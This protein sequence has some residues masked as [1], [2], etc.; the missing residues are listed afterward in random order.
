MPGTREATFPRDGSRVATHVYKGLNEGHGGRGLASKVTCILPLRPFLAPA[1]EVLGASIERLVHRRDV[2]G[3]HGGR[4]LEVQG[5]V[6][7]DAFEGHGG[8]GPTSFEGSS[9]SSARA[10]CDGKG[11]ESPALLEV[12]HRFEGHLR[13]VERGLV[14]P[15]S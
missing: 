1:A 8:R 11:H 10:R 7:P 2:D 15:N 4:G 6:G 3:S 9:C 12:L 5:L 13:G 14:L